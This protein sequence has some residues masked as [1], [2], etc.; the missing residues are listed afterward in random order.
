MADFPGNIRTYT[1]AFAYNEYGYVYSGWDENNV[2]INEF[3]QYNSITNSWIRLPNPEFGKVRG[4][5]TF[6]IDNCTYMTNGKD[7]NNIRVNNHWKYCM[8]E[9]NELNITVYPNPTPNFARISLINLLEAGYIKV[10][11]SLGQLMIK[12]P[13]SAGSYFYDIHLTNSRPGIYFL[14]ITDPHDNLLHTS[15]LVKY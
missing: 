9:Q 4:T 12:D 2:S 3:W 1:V 7:E 8:T 6:L 13:L 11:N 5:S 10:Y 14:Q 15:K